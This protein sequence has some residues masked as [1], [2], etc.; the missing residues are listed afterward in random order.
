M[1]RRGA[2]RNAVRPLRFAWLF[3]LISLAACEIAEFPYYVTTDEPPLL[4]IDFLV[5]RYSWSAEDGR[6]LDTRTAVV[7]PPRNVD[8]G[9]GAQR[10]NAD[11]PV[12]SP[13]L[14]WGGDNTAIGYEAVLIDIQ[15]LRN[16][17]PNETEFHFRLRAFWYAEVNRGD[18]TVD[19]TG[20]RGGTMAKDADGFNWINRGGAEERSIT[21]TRTVTTQES[22][23][24]DGDDIGMARYVV[25]TRVLE[26]A[27]P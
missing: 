23:D 11:G 15:S 24:N 2:R 10:A 17:F 26:I 18:F 20:Y 21:V 5:I 9:W 7:R 12:E 8:V 16:D 1:T 25:A 3:A 19:F 22:S 4:D 13:Y 27:D 6:D 14:Q